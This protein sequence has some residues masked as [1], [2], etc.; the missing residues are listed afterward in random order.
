MFP[1]VLG[2]HPVMNKDRISKVVQIKAYTF[3]ADMT[4]QTFK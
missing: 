1:A 4:E 2:R 3:S